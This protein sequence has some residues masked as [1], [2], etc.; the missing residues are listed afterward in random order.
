MKTSKLNILLLSDIHLGHRNTSTEHITIA[1]TS[2]IQDDTMFSDL[3]MV[4]IAGDLFDRLLQLS[5]PDVTIIY[6]WLHYLLRLCKKHDVLLRVLEGTPSHDNKQPKLVI[7]INREADIGCDVKYMDTLSIEYIDRF[8]IN[9]LYIPDEWL[10]DCSATLAEVHKLLAKHDLDKVDFAIMHG[11]FDY[12]LPSHLLSRVPHHDSKAYLDI[13]KY[14]IFIGHVHQMSSY[15]R[16]FAAGSFDRLRHGEEEDKGMMYFT[17]YDNGMFDAKFIVNKQAQKYITL[18]ITELDTDQALNHI[19]E[20]INTLPIDSH[21]RL[22]VDSTF[23][24]SKSINNVI[25]HH[26]D[27][28]WS[29]ITEKSVKSKMETL[30]VQTK[31]NMT[32]L[33]KEVFPDMLRDRMSPKYDK[34]VVEYTVNLLKEVIDSVDTDT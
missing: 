33:R 2:L 7:D 19:R 25:T 6:G 32:G 3:D 21:I 24:D 30:P 16:I 29:V 9:V 34:P 20:V 14:L 13:V 26:I 17:V 11:Q 18:D 15:D 22:R 4:V 5:S 27:Y 1:L 12:Q 31:V 8:G 23:V 10:P 28:N